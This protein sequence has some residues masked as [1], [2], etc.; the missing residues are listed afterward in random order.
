MF[1]L[2]LRPPLIAG[3]LFLALV[4]MPSR[5]TAQSNAPVLRVE[6]LGKGLAPLDGP[7]QFHVA[8]NH[9]CSLPQTPD[10]DPSAGWEQLTADRTWGAQ[11][12][13]GYTGYAWYRKHLHLTP[14]HDASPD[15]ALLIQEIDDSYE[16][17]W[18]GKLVGRDG[19]MP[20]GPTYPYNPPAQTFGLGPI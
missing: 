9:E 16:L 7:W 3:S 20:P 14:A 15:F 12:H 11:T 8:D 10:D 6:D 5:V 19:T 1:C 4:A 17:Y 18:N 2:P 13:P